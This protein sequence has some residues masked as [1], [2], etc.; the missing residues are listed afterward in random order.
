MGEEYIK[1]DR[2]GTE[3]CE[4]I[5]GD[6]KGSRDRWG[7]QKGAE[8]KNERGFADQAGALNM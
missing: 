5:A 3:I 4:C 8:E 1:D 7:G 2:Q 6:S